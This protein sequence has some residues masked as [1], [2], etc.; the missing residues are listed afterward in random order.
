MDRS[1]ALIVLSSLGA[2]FALGTLERE[3][4]AYKNAERI[5]RIKASQ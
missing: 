4:I 5:F 3:Q 2:A 1:T